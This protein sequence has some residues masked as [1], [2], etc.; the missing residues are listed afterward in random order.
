MSK[1]KAKVA[2]TGFGGLD[3]P[4]PGLAV[5][6]ALRAGWNAPLEIEALCYDVWDTGGWMP[7]VADRLHMATPIS[8]GDE[9]VFARLAEIHEKHKFDVLIPNLD[10]EVPAI[11]RL[12]RRLERMGIRTLLPAP[13][14][15]LAVTKSNLPGFCYTHKIRTPRT[16]LVRDLEDV[17]LYADRFG[18]PL[19]VKGTV[20]GAKK[21]NN[22]IEALHAAQKFNA[23]WGGGVLLQEAIDGQEYVVAM[24]GRA[25]ET[26]L[27]MTPVRKLGVNKRGK[28]V[29][30]AAVD[31]PDLRKQALSIFSK[32][33]WRGPLELEFVQSERD[34]RFYLLEVNC[35][36]PSWIHLSTF[37]GNNLPAL[38]LN[39]ILGAPRKMRK[40]SKTGTAYVR[41]VEEAIVPIKTLR[42][43]QRFGSVT[44][45]KQKAFKTKPGTLNVGITGI[46]NFEVTEPG[47]GIAR[48]LSHVP[49]VNSLTALAYGSFD[50]GLQ[51]SS[52]FS[53][54]YVIPPDTQSDE[55]LLARLTDIQ[56]RAKLDIIIPTLDGELERFQNIAPALKELGITMLLPTKKAAKSLRKDK[57]FSPKQKQDWGA[58]Q[59]TPS[60][61][62]KTRR[63]VKAAWKE[64]G[65]PLILKG[66][67]YGALTAFSLA[68]AEEIW[69]AYQQDDEPVVIAQPVIHG[70][71]VGIGM[72]CDQNS[73]IVESLTMKKLLLCERGKTWGAVSIDLPQVHDS[74]QTFMKAVGWSGPADAEFIRDA[75]SDRY[76]LIEINPRLPAWSGFSDL[77]GGHLARQIVRLASGQE[78]VPVEST[79]EMLFMRASEEIPTTGQALA[80]FAN[81]GE[82]HHG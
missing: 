68:E 21:V 58:F 4:E 82:L 18:F 70:E 63:D 22:S 65:S 36:F 12:S 41:D 49:E 38:L 46:S 5:A 14:D 72:V 39:E 54:G 32:L 20:A 57:L 61:L 30:G 31:N 47:L 15:A 67:Q 23:K 81:R 80:L 62:V 2:L 71:E 77:Q 25:D 73:T 56:D 66:H 17:P 35:R 43:L 42:Q 76:Y 34:G 11:S 13:E 75:M 55:K 59:L 6:R 19:F 74:L 27:A 48:M 3:N 10:L 24:I 7:G 33:H 44:P 60:R 45:P 69:E 29:V 50:T 37:A 26:C 64:Y 51:R 78:A 1:L 16:M 28:G 9:A 8:L 52:A 40:N 53:S 79:Q